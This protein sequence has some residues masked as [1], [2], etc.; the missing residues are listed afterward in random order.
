MQQSDF[1]AEMLQLESIYF[2][3]RSEGQLKKLREAWYRTFADVDVRDFA[4][5]IEQYKS[6]QEGQREPRPAAIYWLAKEARRNRMIEERPV[7]T[8]KFGPPEH[9]CCAKLE[10]ARKAIVE[11]KKA[12][13]AVGE[14]RR[15]ASTLPKVSEARALLAFVGP[16]AYEA[17]HVECSADKCRCPFC[18]HEFTKMINP[19]IVWLAK[20]YPIQTQNW[21][22]YFKGLLV[23]DSC[24]AALK[25]GARIAIESK[26]DGPVKP[27]PIVGHAQTQAQDYKAEAAGNHEPI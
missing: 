27:R 7:M 11:Y 15:R 18:G 24:D 6:S 3:N 5:A 14:A 20:K 17:I 13:S 1:D 19:M 10:R 4:T 21:I 16:D 22:P 8:V 23:C 12:Q 26:P 2:S 25:N 9:Q